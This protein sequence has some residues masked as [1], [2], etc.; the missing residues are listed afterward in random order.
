MFLLIFLQHFQQG[1]PK[2]LSFNF[3]NCFSQIFNFDIFYHTQDGKYDFRIMWHGICC[4]DIIS[5]LFV[6][7]QKWIQFRYYVGPRLNA[8]EWFMFTYGFCLF[9]FE[10]VYNILLKFINLTKTLRHFSLC[11][12]IFTLNVDTSIWNLREPRYKI[13]TENN[14][15]CLTMFLKYWKFFFLYIAFNNVNKI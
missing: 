15:L 5:L 1:H 2:N 4:D 8:S 6:S 10:I 3:F 12:F 13:Q 14:S 11:K 9:Y 7:I